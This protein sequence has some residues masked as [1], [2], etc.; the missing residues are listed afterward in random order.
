MKSF[1]L[2]MCFS[3]LNLEISQQSCGLLRIVHIR[4]LFQLFQNVGY[5]SD[6]ALDVQVLFAFPIV[7][8][9]KSEHYDRSELLLVVFGGDHNLVLPFET[10][11]LYVW[12]QP[13]TIAK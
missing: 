9:N 13:S 3:L 1:F 6:C 12:R 2:L 8:A 5:V 7:Q 10:I 4:C 11:V